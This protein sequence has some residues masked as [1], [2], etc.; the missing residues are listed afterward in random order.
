GFIF[1]AYHLLGDSTVIYNVLIPALIAGR[2][3]AKGSKAYRRAQQLLEHVG[4]SHR[5]DFLAKLLSGGEKQR[6]AIARALM[7]DPHLLLA[8]E[9]SGNLDQT[10]SAHIHQLLIQAAKQHQKGLLIVTHNL[11]LAALCDRRLILR[12][13]KLYNED[14]QPWTKPI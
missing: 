7:N 5:Q 10:T 13:G 11:E 12:G 9:P 14:T 1:Q 6:V 8:D 3:I 2:N 4:L